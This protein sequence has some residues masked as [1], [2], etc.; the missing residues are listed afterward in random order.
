M[1]ALEW[2][3]DVMRW[4]VDDQMIHTTKE[5]IPHAP[6]YLILNTAVG[7]GWP[8]DPDATTVFPQY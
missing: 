5:G 4:F 1:Y 2:E 8:G 6:H 7:G 3:P